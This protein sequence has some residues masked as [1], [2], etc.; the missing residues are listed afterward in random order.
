MDEK[1]ASI[2]PA[3]LMGR[4]ETNH[5]TQPQGYESPTEGDKSG[6]TI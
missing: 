3:G 2:I 4:W 1:K 6:H 5:R